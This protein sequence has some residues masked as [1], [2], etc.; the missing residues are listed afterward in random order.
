MSN[1]K[2]KLVFSHYDDDLNAIMYPK[3]NITMSDT[4]IHFDDRL[5]PYEF[6]I[7]SLFKHHYI[8]Y[9]SKYRWV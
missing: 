6:Y 8:K 3:L 2:K 1:N 4:Q 9:H 7:Q 5:R